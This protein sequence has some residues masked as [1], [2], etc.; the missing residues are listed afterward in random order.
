MKSDE[1]LERET[2]ELIS[3]YVSMVI[4]A[5]GEES[6]LFVDEKEITALCLGYAWS[7]G[8]SAEEKRKIF[9]IIQRGR[10]QAARRYDRTAADS[11]KEEFI[12][13]I[14]NEDER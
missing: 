5:S 6:A 9:E 1:E 2:K 10:E 3:F 4:K 12:R 13:I 11:I 7:Q 14:Q 8:E